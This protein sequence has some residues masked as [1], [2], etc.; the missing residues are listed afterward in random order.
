MEQRCTRQAHCRVPLSFE[1]PPALVLPPLRGIGILMPVQPEVEPVDGS[2][3]RRVLLRRDLKRVV[4]S[5]VFGVLVKLHREPQL[6]HSCQQLHSPHGSTPSEP[7]ISNVARIRSTVKPGL[8]SSQ[9]A[10]PAPNGGAPLS[11]EPFEIPVPKRQNSF[12]RTP[13]NAAKYVNG[14]VLVHD[15]NASDSHYQ[16]GWAAIHI[17][18]FEWDWFHP[19]APVVLRSLEGQQAVGCAE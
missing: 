9:A 12:R 8:C 15:L 4:R 11:A 5:P 2:L 3:L 14:T 7:I 16:S 13:V 10:S 19:H 17:A 1:L 6:A 18:C